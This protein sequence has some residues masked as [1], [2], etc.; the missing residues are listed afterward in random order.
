MTA[1]PTLWGLV[2]RNQRAREQLPHSR[3]VVATSSGEP[4]PAP[5]LRSMLHLLPQE[6]RLL[7][8]YGS[9]ETTADCTCAILTAKDLDSLHPPAGRPL[10]GFQVLTVRQEQGLFQCCLPGEAGQILV[11]GK[12]LAAGYLGAPEATGIHPPCFLPL[13]H[14][15]IRGLPIN[16]DGGTN[17]F[18]PGD[19]GRLDSAGSLTP[20]GRWQ[21]DGAAALV[22]IRGERVHA[23]AW[24]EDQLGSRPGVLHVAARFIEP[25]VLQCYVQL[26]DRQ[27]MGQLADWLSG[28]LPETG[29][30]QVLLAPLPGPWPVAED[31]GK[32]LTRALPDPATLAY[33]EVR[34]GSSGTQRA[35][36]WTEAG[37][38]AAFCRT[39]GLPLEPTTDFFQA[40]GDSLAATQVAEL[41]DLPSLE[42]LALH[43][44]A[45]GLAKALQGRP[46]R[47]GSLPPSKRARFPGLPPPVS[48]SSASRILQPWA[49][50]S[51]VSWL[52]IGRYGCLQLDRDGECRRAEVPALPDAPTVARIKWRRQLVDCVDSSAALLVPMD[53]NGS[54]RASQALLII[55]SHGGR[56]AALEA[57]S[58]ACIWSMD[59]KCRF[60]ASVCPSSDLSVLVLGSREG[61][62]LL[63]RAEDGQ[64]L[65][66]WEEGAGPFKA[67]PVLSPASRRIYLASQSGHV[68]SVEPTASA[69][70]TWEPSIAALGET[71]SCPPLFAC[72]WAACFSLKGSCHLI[73]DQ[74]QGPGD[75]LPP[76]PVS[77]PEGSAIFGRPLLLDPKDG[78]AVALVAS[79]AGFVSEVTWG[80]QGDIQSLRRWSSPLVPE[81][82]FL[83]PVPVQGEASLIASSKGGGAL[84][85]GPKTELVTRLPA[86]LTTILP[87]RGSA[88][89]LTASSEGQLGLCSLLEDDW[90]PLG[91]PLPEVTFSTGVALG[92]LYFSGSRG[93]FIYCIDLFSTQM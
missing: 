80:T 44:S 5:L 66:R 76:V 42:L 6:C 19:V 15:A 14:P 20:L 60:E 57:A 78:R 84:L 37:I 85:L 40:G 83:G 50:A 12:G 52:F 73:R 81:P 54:F 13:S 23:A 63:L 79:V 70:D 43:P 69:A 72:G 30:P 38:T 65:S 86:S 8:I 88:E 1:V 46:E 75:H 29:F 11:A 89:L 55:A 67:D 92:G 93:D 77:Q 3:L 59:F 17:V 62:V 49:G 39:L 18:L 47:E 36:P 90:R 56:V 31:S 51:I 48:S 16:A 82:V 22:N 21:G 33:M 2:L 41:L 7:N 45:R 71:V 32:V 28:R 10:P 64:E 74:R 25:N 26:E 58:G 68:V 27:P 24:V 61:T 53:A 91:P 9:T 87:L 34:P 4:L 35:F